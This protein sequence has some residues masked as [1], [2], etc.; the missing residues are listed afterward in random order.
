MENVIKKHNINV[1]GDKNA[2]NWSTIT[3]STK[4]D[5]WDNT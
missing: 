4:G 5:K 3:W 2:K 1:I